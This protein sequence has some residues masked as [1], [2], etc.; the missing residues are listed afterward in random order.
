VS[1]LARDDTLTLVHSAHDADHDDAVVLAELLR[2]G[3]PK[4]GKRR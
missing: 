1:G 3:L 2:R 4:P